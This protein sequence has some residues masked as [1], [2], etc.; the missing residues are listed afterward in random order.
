MVLG[1]LAIIAVIMMNS[2][3]GFRKNQALRTDTSTIVE[4]LR[5][6]RNQTLASKN[7]TNYGV[8]FAAS[9]VTI[10]T[11]GTYDVS[12]STNQNFDLSSS[13]NILTIS[14]TGGGND[15]VFQR[16]S[17]AVSASGTIVISSPGISQTKTVT[18][19]KTGLV[20]SN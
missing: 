15:V 2:F 4:V 18:I 10:F 1:V 3:L 13:D 6:A 20:E 7:S 16:L 19:Y 8:H 17:G 14:L 11:G 9:R 5:Q 12:T